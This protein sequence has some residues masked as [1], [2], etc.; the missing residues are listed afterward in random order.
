MHYLLLLALIPL[1]TGQLYLD[2]GT[3][4][5]HTLLLENDLLDFVDQ[6]VKLEARQD[7]GTVVL[8][9]TEVISS[10]PSPTP[11]DDPFATDLLDLTEAYSQTPTPDI[12]TTPA[13]TTSPTPET[14]QEE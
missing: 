4:H 13:E 1:A 2:E 6:D 5:T 3:F 8:D 9:G 7:E 14:G 11:E 12:T 10:T